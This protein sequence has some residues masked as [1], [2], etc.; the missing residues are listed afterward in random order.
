LLDHHGLK[1]D[2]N[3]NRNTRKPT[4]AWKLNNS[5]FI[6]LCIRE[7]RKKEIRDFLEFNENE[8]TTYP[9]LW[10]TIKVLLRGKFI[11][12]SASKKNRKF[13]YQ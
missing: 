12:L 10:D 4:H 7:E 1:L 11:I 5:P 9:N 6:N 3:N 13:S 2:F 8:I